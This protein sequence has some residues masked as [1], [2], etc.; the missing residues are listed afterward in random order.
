M[1][2]NPDGF[3][4]SI[5]TFAKRETEP[6]FVKWETEPPFRKVG[7]KAPLRK[8]GLGGFRSA[9]KPG[10]KL[11]SLSKAKSFGFFQKSNE[12]GE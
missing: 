1:P 12:V 7:D 8:G 4:K 9:G 10:I 6:P 2:L 3:V 5:I 11:S